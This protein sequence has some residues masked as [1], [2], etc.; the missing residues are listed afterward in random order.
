MS[1]RKKRKAPAGVAHLLRQRGKKR[2]WTGWLAGAEVALGTADAVEAGKRLNELAAKRERTARDDQ[3]PKTIRLAALAAKYIESVQPPHRSPRTAQS[4]ES[5][6][7]KF[8]EFAE[9][10]NIVDAERVTTKLVQQ[11]I[12][13]RA[14]AG[15]SAR[16]I[17]RD[18]T[19]VAN[20]YR[21][22][23]RAELLVAQPFT[24]EAYGQLRLREPTPAPNLR[25]L[26]DAQVDA[27]LKRAYE[28]LHV[29]Y[30]ALFE[31]VAGCGARLDEAFHLDASDLD[32]ARRI[33]RITPKPNWST[34]NYKFREIP[35]SE[36]TIKAARIFVR[37]R[38]DVSLDRKAVWNQLQRARKDVGLP[39]FSPHDLRRAWASAMHHRGASLKAISVWLGHGSLGVTERYVR[40]VET[41]G[42][43][44][45]P[46]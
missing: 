1:K 31:V 2:F 5:R 13:E 41:D 32:V 16:T 27:F 28:V 14:K 23:V 19:P 4:I 39:R 45:L 26:S 24:A 22:G 12:D 34:K 10:K 40:V 6:V 17:N 25:T 9:E 20:M 18:V 8:V 29:A 15:I 46:R 43:R 42:H 35:A 38:G 44:F 33:I 11:F 7:L 3:A 37:S 36:A 21:F 30:A